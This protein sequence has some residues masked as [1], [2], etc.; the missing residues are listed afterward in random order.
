MTEEMKRGAAG[1]RCA[2]SAG[3]PAAADGRAAAPD[4]NSLALAF[5]GDAVYEQY[6]RERLVRSGRCRG[7]AD[8]MHR[9]AA[10]FVR[11]SAQAEVIRAL[12]PELSEE[13]QRTALRAR[14][15]RIA[16]KPKNA[17]A[18]TYKW[19]TGFEALLGSLKL[20]GREE[21]LR[22]LMDRAWEL[23]DRGEA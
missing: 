6:I 5:L 12:L 19:A 8:L 11:A 7:R 14:N 23:L 4:E 13:E 22:E 9:Q 16:T 15:H 10:S 2:D 18:A 3:A 17:D 1:V 21:R 20:A